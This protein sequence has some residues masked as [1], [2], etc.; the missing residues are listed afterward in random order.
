MN[1]PGSS[2]SS[3]ARPIDTGP[4]PGSRF[5]A[6]QSSSHPGFTHLSL[7]RRLGKYLIHVRVDL[8]IGY[9]KRSPIGNGREYWS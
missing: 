5:R 8:Q 3:S 6:I 1:R 4:R 7:W 9:S 2:Q